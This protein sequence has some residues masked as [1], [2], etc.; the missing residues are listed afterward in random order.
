MTCRVKASVELG[1]MTGKI[2]YP[3]SA[4]RCCNEIGKCYYSW[5]K[6]LQISQVHMIVNNNLPTLTNKSS[7][8]EC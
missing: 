1:K 3:F 7:L 4:V 6:I 5:S 2:K 8:T